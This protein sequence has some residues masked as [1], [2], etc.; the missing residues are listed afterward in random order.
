MISS[1]PAALTTV[2]AAL[3]IPERVERDRDDRSA[4]TFIVSRR[5]SI[6][7]VFEVPVINIG[8]SA[9][10]NSGLS[11][12]CAW[13]AA[14]VDRSYGPGETIRNSTPEPQPGIQGEGSVGCLEGREDAGRIGTIIRRSR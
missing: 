4:E 2:L 9:N 12:I 7:A 14:I 13:T 8:G 5:R 3:P 10:L 1:R 6:D 11:G